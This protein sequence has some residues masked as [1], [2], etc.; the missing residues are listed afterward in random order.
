LPSKFWCRP[1]WSGAAL[2]GTYASHYP[3]VAKVG[4]AQCNQTRT[5]LQN[6]T[7]LDPPGPA[8]AA[9]D[10]VALAFDDPGDTNAEQPF[11]DIRKIVAVDN[12]ERRPDEMVF[13]GCGCDI[14]QSLIGFPSR[15]RRSPVGV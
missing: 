6:N 13:F 4:L 15:V 8:A 7:I 1:F 9:V 11:L 10:L 14:N 5:Y 12:P 2:T 3:P